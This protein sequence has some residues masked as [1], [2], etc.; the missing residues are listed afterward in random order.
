MVFHFI[1]ESAKTSHGETYRL[2]IKWRVASRGPFGRDFNILFI[3]PTRRELLPFCLSRQIK[4]RAYRRK[5][6]DRHDAFLGAFAQSLRIL[7]DDDTMTRD[8]DFE[9]G[10]RH[11]LS[12]VVTWFFAAA[13]PDDFPSEVRALLQKEIDEYEAEP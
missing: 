4:Q 5:T 2:R 7:L 13:D 12:R 11:A 1:P 8:D 9:I 3:I 10:Y 6:M